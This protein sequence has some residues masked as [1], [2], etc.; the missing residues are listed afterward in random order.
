MSY[1]YQYQTPGF[2]SSGKP[3]DPGI[4]GPSLPYVNS[5]GGTRQ[6]AVIK[7]WREQVAAISIGLINLVLGVLVLAAYLHTGP[8]Y[9]IF[10]PLEDLSGPIV[11]TANI[12]AAI[13]AIATLISRMGRYVAVEIRELGFGDE[14]S[15]ARKLQSDSGVRYRQVYHSGTLIGHRSSLAESSFYS[16]SPWD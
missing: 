4:Q 6:P 7:L 10:I 11:N 9:A 5:P 15:E 8:L 2:D 13:A 3:L 12:G 1:S 16:P 14:L